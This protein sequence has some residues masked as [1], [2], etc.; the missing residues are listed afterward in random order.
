MTGPPAAEVLLVMEAEDEVA[1][2]LDGPADAEVAPLVKVV[3]EEVPALDDEEVIELEVVC[4]SD[5][6]LCAE[7]VNC[8][9]EDT[10]ALS[11]SDETPWL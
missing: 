2:T 8:P 11:V 7:E 10:D 9:L 6:E 3:R 1:G 5:A 4:T